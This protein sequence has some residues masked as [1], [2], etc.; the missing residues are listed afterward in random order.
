MRVPALAGGARKD[1]GVW[2]RHSFCH[3][4]IGQRTLS[5]QIDRT[6][7]VGYSCRRTVSIIVLRLVLYSSS[8]YQPCQV[9]V[10]VKGWW[11]LT[12]TEVSD[13]F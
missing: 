9:V 7:Q 8:S 13:A 2:H 3:T 5:Y 1:G 4:L 12:S 10:S 11:G 6:T